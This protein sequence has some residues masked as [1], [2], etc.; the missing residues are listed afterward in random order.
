[1][2]FSVPVPLPETLDHQITAYKLDRP[3]ALGEKPAF[4]LEF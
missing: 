1:M 2:N 4:Y 3:K